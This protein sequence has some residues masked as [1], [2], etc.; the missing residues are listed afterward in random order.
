MGIE[1]EYWRRSG[2]FLADLE[3]IPRNIQ[4]ADFCQISTAMLKAN[5][6]MLL[7]VFWVIQRQI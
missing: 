4:H 7:T 5:K 1:R 3:H 2:V 6:K